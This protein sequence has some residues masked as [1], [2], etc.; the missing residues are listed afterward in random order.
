MKK[1]T[2][3]FVFLFPLFTAFS[4]QVGGSG[5]FIQGGVEDG[6][7]L[8]HAYITPINKTIVFGLSNTS[9]TKNRYREDQ[10]KLLISLQLAY[11]NIPE[12]DKTYD[13]SQLQLQ[14]LEAKDPDQSIAQ[15]VFGDSLKSV[16]IATKKKDIFGRRL[17][18]FNTPTGGQANAIPLPHI[19][20]TYRMKKT[21]L[22]FGLIPYVKIPDS[23]LKL[24]MLRAGFQQNLTAFIESLQESPLGLNLQASAGI[25]YAHTPLNVKP[26]G[27]FIPISPI[28]GSHTGPYDN[29][30]LNIFYTSFQLSFYVNY[31]LFDTIDLFAGAGYNMGNSRILL[32]G[33]YPVYVAD[34]TGSAS[35]VA[36][37]VV[38]PLDME[39]AFSR[40]KYDMGAR[41]DFSKFYLQLNY[42]M[43]TYGGVSAGFG[44][45]L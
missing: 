6:E 12:E 28:T 24:G 36:D 31:T 41:F 4:Q 26:E 32:S 27:F 44:Y 23:D 25:F 9:Y 39:D 15:T 8:I 45:K 11:V 17:F 35:L 42:N 1:R 7:K 5:N 38:D 21:N 2:F 30:E 19:G 37:D 10:A 14:Y 18:E 22:D 43:T 3:L 20:L 16:V 33:K 40:I 29:Q 13:I 34:P